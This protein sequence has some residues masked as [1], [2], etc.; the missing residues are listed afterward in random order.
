MSDS[1]HDI[2]GYRPIDVKDMP[3]FNFFHPSEVEQARKV[4]KRGILLD[5]AAVLHTVHLRSRDG[6]YVKCECSFT[7]VQD[8][9]VA[10]IGKFNSSYKSDRKLFCVYHLR[11][12]A[13]RYAPCIVGP[14]H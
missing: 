13:I 8:A 1:V 9:L 3:A 2:L 11:A 4:H 12:S 10:C 7:I 5:K 6:G 14:I